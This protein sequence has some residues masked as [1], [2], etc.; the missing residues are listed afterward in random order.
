MFDRGIEW[1][2][3]RMMEVRDKKR[4]QRL[5]GE[6]ERE[7]LICSFMTQ[8]F[9]FFFHSLKVNNHF[10]QIYVQLID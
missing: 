3:L 1:Q 10:Q 4:D 8:D 6:R 2:I 7:M 9:F 5:I